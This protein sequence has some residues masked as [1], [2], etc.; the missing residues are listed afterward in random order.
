MTAFIQIVELSSDVLHA[1]VD[2][3]RISAFSY[4][5][6]M[7]NIYKEALF[8]IFAMVEVNAPDIPPN[9][10][11]GLISSQNAMLSLGRAGTRYYFDI[12]LQTGL[13]AAVLVNCAATSKYF[14][15][16]W[17][18]L[19]ITRPLLWSEPRDPGRCTTSITLNPPPRSFNGNSVHVF[20]YQPFQT[21]TSP[22]NMLLSRTQMWKWPIDGAQ[23]KFANI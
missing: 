18:S 11:V 5:F 22:W 23:L 13:P 3:S 7:C 9:L 8:E 10:K 21:P 16:A 15:S 20:F 17:V 19:F 14:I 4:Y 12:V 1:L 2:Q 6:T